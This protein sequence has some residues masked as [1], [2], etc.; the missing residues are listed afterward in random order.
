MDYLIAGILAQLFVQKSSLHRVVDAKNVKEPEEKS[1]ISSSKSTFLFEFTYSTLPLFQVVTRRN[2]TVKIL[3]KYVHFSTGLFSSFRFV[4]TYRHSLPRACFAKCS[5]NFRILHILHFH[6]KLSHAGKNL[7][8]VI[9]DM[10]I[11]VQVYTRNL[12]NQQLSSDNEW[13]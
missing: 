1:Y 4:V 10:F 5:L 3:I 9:L 12:A 7:T 8:V 13:L 11:S 2:L 6:W